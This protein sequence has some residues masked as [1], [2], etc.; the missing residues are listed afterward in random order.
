MKPRRS[1]RYS[2]CLV[3]PLHWLHWRLAAKKVPLPCDSTALAAKKVPL[4]CVSTALAAK[5]LP[6]SC[7]HHDRQKLPL[8]CV[9][10]AF[11]TEEAPVLGH[12]PK[13]EAIPP[14]KCVQL[15]NMVTMKDL[16]VAAQRLSAPPLL[17]SSAP[18]LLRSSSGLHPR[19]RPLSLACCCSLRLFDRCA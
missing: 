16:K 12:S 19:P 15:C 4:P 17:R 3:F 18:P 1:V 7:G 6:L 10:T 13:A 9:S 14:S 8:P 2:L 11:A 5:T